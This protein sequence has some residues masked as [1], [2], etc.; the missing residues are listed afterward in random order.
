MSSP[1]G[2]ANANLR[3][4]SGRHPRCVVAMW[5]VLIASL[6]WPIL[7]PPEAV[8]ETETERGYRIKVAFLLNFA[9][10]VKWPK[11]SF[12]DSESSFVICHLGGSQTRALFDTSYADRMVRRHPIA[13]RHP[14][15]AG[16]VLGCHIIMITAERS[17][18][19]AGF[20]AAVAGK[21]ILTIGETESFA[22]SGGMIGF[23][24]E[25]SKIR[26]EINLDAAKNARLRISSRLLQLAR[27]VS[28]DWE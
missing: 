27:L 12:K 14:S 11:E 5:A 6:A 20:I 18:Q 9:S 17:E 1:E 16:D 13:V 23:Y 26:F 8:G 10:L 4:G 19:A 2:R 22:L 15:R 7:T 3:R 24:N 28:S 25:G 21:S